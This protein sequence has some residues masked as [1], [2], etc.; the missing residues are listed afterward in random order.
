MPDQEDARKNEELRRLVSDLMVYHRMSDT[1][2]FLNYGQL[3]R[4]GSSQ[5]L[6]P[7]TIRQLVN[8]SRAHTEAP[9]HIDNIEARDV[10]LQVS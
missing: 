5:G 6:R 10:S 7:V 3:Q 9:F 4:E 2:E 1:M 8:A